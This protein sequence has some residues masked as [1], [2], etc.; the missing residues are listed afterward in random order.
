MEKLTTPQLSSIEHMRNGPI[1]NDQSLLL[2]S[3]TRAAM[4]GRSYSGTR[5]GSAVRVQDDWRIYT[6]TNLSIASPSLTVCAE[7]MAVQN[8]SADGNRI[9]T[10]V[11]VYSPDYEM[12]SPC[13]LCRQVIIELAVNAEMLVWMS[14]LSQ[15]TH[16]PQWEAHTIG[17]L[18]PFAYKKARRR[19]V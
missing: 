8:A 9:I 6:G 17:E 14:G 19:T 18:L 15:D 1:T 3:A 5:V 13:G 2:E 12:I 10:E 11:A 4:W 7:R 16:L